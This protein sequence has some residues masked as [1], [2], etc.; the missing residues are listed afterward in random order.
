[1]IGRQTGTRRGETMI[2]QMLQI[3]QLAHSYSTNYIFNKIYFYSTKIFVQLQPKIISFNNNICSTY[4]KLFLFNKSN[5]I[6][7]QPKIILLNNKLP[8]HSKYHHSTK[9]PIPPQ[10][11]KT[12]L[13]YA[14][15]TSKTC[16]IHNRQTSKLPCYPMV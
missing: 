4:T 6:Q 11:Y 5:I 9:F 13:S 10:L 12:T 16:Q 14:S 3:Q 1:M 15:S 7:L 8:G 2:S